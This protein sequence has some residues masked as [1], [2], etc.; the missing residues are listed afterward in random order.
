M[1]TYGTNPGMGIPVTGRVPESDA[2]AAEQRA[3]SRRRSSTW[4]SRPGEPLLGKQ[5]DVVFIGSCTNSRLERPPRRGAA[6]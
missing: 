6:S 2:D 5:I 1:I 3:A 4:A